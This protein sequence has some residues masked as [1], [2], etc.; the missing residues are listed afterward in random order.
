MQASM[1]LAYDNT[2]APLSEATLTV[3]SMRDW[4]ASGVKSLSLWFRGAD[5]NTGQ[6]YLKIN[7]TKVPYNGNATDLAKPLWTRWNL[8]LST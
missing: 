7:N 8:D 1:P 2:T 5:K 3:A 6:L 4:T